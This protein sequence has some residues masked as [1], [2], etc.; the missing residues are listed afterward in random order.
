MK[1]RLMDLICP[2]CGAEIQD[3]Y[4]WDDEPLP[5]CCEIEMQEKISAPQF[6][7]ATGFFTGMT[8]ES[9]PAKK[10]ELTWTDED[11]KKWRYDGK[12][13]VAI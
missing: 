7:F 13:K 11:G 6:A 2:I 10:S 9:D 5:A 3:H 8:P 4:R 12:R 1:C